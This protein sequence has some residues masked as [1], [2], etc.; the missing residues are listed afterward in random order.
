VKPERAMADLVEK[1]RKV[2]QKG[3]T[4]PPPPIPQTVEMELIPIR[5]VK[6]MNSMPRIGK[7]SLC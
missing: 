5:R 7:T 4:R 3:I 2:I 6:P 1:P